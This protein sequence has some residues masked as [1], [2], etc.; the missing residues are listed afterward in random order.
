[1]RIDALADA[2]SAGHGA[3]E[4]ADALACEHVRHR[5][6]AFLAAGE[7]RS[8]PAGADMQPEQLG[9]FPPDRHFPALAA[10]AG[11]DRDHA[12]GEAHVLD[13]HGVG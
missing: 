11:A 9:Q 5:A 13:A 3:D 10:F 12:L 4:L 6:G 1:M 8:C 7:Q 2:G